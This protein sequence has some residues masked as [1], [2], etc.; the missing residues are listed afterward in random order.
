MT[1]L[2]H[3]PEPARVCL[4]SVELDCQIQDLVVVHGYKEPLHLGHLRL[5]GHLSMK[6]H[7]TVLISI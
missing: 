1:F 3:S 4:L 6:N 7:K 5:L 2:S